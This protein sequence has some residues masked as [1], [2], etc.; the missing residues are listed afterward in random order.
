MLEEC[1]TKFYQKA[2]W[3]F[4]YVLLTF[5]KSRKVLLRIYEFFIVFT[6]YFS[7]SIYFLSAL[8]QA[9]LSRASC[10]AALIDYHAVFLLST[11]Y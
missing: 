7:R 1:H 11:T 5:C 10:E 6:V 9:D 4:V 3:L 2:V 8:F